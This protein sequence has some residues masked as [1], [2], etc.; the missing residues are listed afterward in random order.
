VPHAGWYKKHDRKNNRRAG[1]G[2]NLKCDRP[3]ELVILGYGGYP[4]LVQKPLFLHVV[5]L[6]NKW[7][8]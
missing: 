2:S 5:T 6:F 7:D 3:P 1:V 8:L 4:E